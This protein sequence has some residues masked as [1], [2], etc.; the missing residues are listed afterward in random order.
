[1]KDDQTSVRILVFQGEAEK[2][3]D[4]EPLGEFV[5]SGLRKAR[6]SEVEVEVTFEI[7]ADGIVSVSAKDLE[8]GQE[9][10]IKLIAGS[11][12]TEAEISEMKV[13]TQDH[14]VSAAT[15]EE[16]ERAR[17]NIEQLIEQAESMMPKVEKIL[18]GTPFDK[19][20]LGA[21]RAVLADARSA[22]ERRDAAKVASV[23]APLARTVKMFRGLVQSD[24]GESE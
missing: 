4:N 5:L 20:S 18:A 1:V 23:A 6:R 24:R 7:S 21:V 13:E 19:E 16:A 14:V 15:E 22:I 12:L 2:A 10:S 8:T 9:Q 3:Q 17:Q 11:G